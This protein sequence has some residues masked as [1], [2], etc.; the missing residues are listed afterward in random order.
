M[1]NDK[2]IWDFLKSQGLTDA[3]VAGLMGNLY[4]ESGL[5]PN[6]LQNN[7][8]AALGWT[9]EQYTTAVDNGTYTREQFINDGYGY[10][11]PQWT[12][13]GWKEDY[14]DSTKEKGVSIGDLTNNLEQ[15]TKIIAR[16][17]KVV[18]ET[19]KTATD[20]M[21]ASTSVLVNFERPADQSDTTK[22]KRAAF[23]QQYYDEFVN[24]EEEEEMSY[25][26][27][28]KYQAQYE[29]EQGA[30]PPSTWAANN[31]ISEQA[32]QKGLTVD[33]S[34]PRAFATR[35]EVQQMILGYDEKKGG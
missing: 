22:T 9:D 4:V 15:L 21:T 34:R 25:E 6:N 26:T 17:C 27:F 16:D 28:K 30:L 31:N 20:V 23:G 35:E 14:Y 32:K 1:S 7:G 33:A 24:V 5:L 29:Q 12:F 3:G 10:G 8:N 18:W 13:S 11:L 2:Q 19:L